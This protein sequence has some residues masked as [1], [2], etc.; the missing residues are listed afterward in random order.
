MINNEYICELSI[1]F[2]VEYLLN[3]INNYKQ[4]LSLLK[5]QRLV[6]NDQYLTSI[7]SKFQILS[8]IWNFYDFEPNKILGC[9]IDSERSCALNIPLKG[10][11]Q[12]TTTFYNLPNTVDLE[13]DDK[14]KLNWVRDCNNKV[15][16]FTLTRPTLIKN[17]VPHSVINGPARRIIMSWSITKGITFEEAR[18]FFKNEV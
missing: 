9:H 6:T 13:Y 15:F 1:D 3:L 8:P 7:Q 17:S 5:H 18:E 11:E 10:T 2:D 4:D 14:R 12:S 16:E